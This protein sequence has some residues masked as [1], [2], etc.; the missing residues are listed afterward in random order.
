MNKNPSLSLLKQGYLFPEIA[1][2]MAAFQKENPHAEIISL[3]IGDTT[4]AFPPEW[5][6]PF[7]SFANAL[8]TPQGY[9]GYGPSEGWL[10]LR[11]KISSIFYKGYISADEIFVSDGAKSDISRLQLLFSP[12]CRIALQDPVYPAYVDSSLLFGKKEITYLPC[13][14]E[15]GFFPDLSKACGV[16]LLFINYPNNPTGAMAT[17]SD[18]QTLIDF[19]RSRKIILI[20]DAAYSAFIQDEALPKSIYELEG[21]KDVAIEIN[22]FSKMAG[23]TGVRLGWSVVPKSLRFSDGSSIHD[24]WV[25]IVNTTFNAPSILSQSLGES[26]LNPIN[27]PLTHKINSSYLERGEKLKKTLKSLGFSVFGGEHCPY[28]WVEMRGFK[29]S[30]DA[31][32]ALLKGA[33]L[34]TIPGSGFGPSGE[35]FLRIS[36][37]AKEEQIEKACQR[38]KEY[39]SLDSSKKKSS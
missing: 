29:S 19:C 17:R 25:R 3:G 5:V 1:K 7:L 36:A 11:E 13:T 21:A 24:S 8:S 18:L 30:W 37:F 20:Y 16:D 14:K 23:F 22:S 28:L 33:H 10:S 12:N 39:F 34:V 15:N 38:L 27:F 35:G 32:D 31:F 9:M 26:V 6:D 2:R 4:S